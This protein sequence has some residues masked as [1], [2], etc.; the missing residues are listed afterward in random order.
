MRFQVAAKGTIK[1]HSLKRV[2]P[3]QT[4]RHSVIQRTKRV[5]RC[6]ESRR[7]FGQSGFEPPEKNVEKDTEKDG[8][9]RT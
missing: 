2:R 3:I 6:S 8:A 1:T 5:L 4:F 7:L 9:G